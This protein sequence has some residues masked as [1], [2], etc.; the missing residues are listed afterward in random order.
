[1]KQAAILGMGAIGRSLIADWLNHEPRG[2]SLAAIGGRPAQLE[3]LDGL[4]LGETAL[5]TDCAVMLERPLDA[6]VEAAGHDAVRQWGVAILERGCD[7][8]LL[9]AG[10]LAD[11]ALHDRLLAAARQSRAHIV[12]P[13]GA[14]GGFEALK[15]LACSEGA[16]VTLR[17]IKPVAAWK[18]TPADE[19]L[20]V[21]A[22]DA[23][24]MVFRGTAREAASL[25]PRNSNMAASVALAGIGFDRTVVELYAD[26]DATGNRA[27]L[28]ART[29]TC[30]LKV[31]LAGRAEAHNPK[32][33]A[34]VRSSVL[35]ALERAEAALRVG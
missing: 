30:M 8:F 1:M 20:R 12:I 21:R 6:V 25:F 18:G 33:S 32:S 14:L 23:R 10:A 17:S 9:S 15:A 19:M 2:W 35:A 24:I 26:P 5:F 7:L 28:E 4:P 16:E 11:Q 27:I 22:P 34:I 31:E 3:A 29:P 13:S